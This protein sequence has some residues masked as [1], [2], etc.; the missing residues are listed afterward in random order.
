MEINPS[1]FE[2]DESK[3]AILKESD[4]IR[5]EIFSD[6][7]K[8]HLSLNVK[9]E[10]VVADISA[11]PKCVYKKAYFLGK[12]EVISR[13]KKIRSH[14]CM[15]IRTRIEKKNTNSLHAIFKCLFI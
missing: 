9:S 7:L 8:N 11:G 13:W 12:H 14:V 4:K 6:L 15:I 2:S 1:E 10:K 5:H 3:Y